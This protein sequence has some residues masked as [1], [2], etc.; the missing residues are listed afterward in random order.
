MIWNTLRYCVNGI[1]TYFPDAIG[2]SDNMTIEENVLIGTWKA[3]EYGKGIVIT[4]HLHATESKEIKKYYESYSVVRITN[5]T[6]IN[7]TCP[8]AIYR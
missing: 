3:V 1:V 8:L 2:N 7:Y 5:N 4:T 6:I